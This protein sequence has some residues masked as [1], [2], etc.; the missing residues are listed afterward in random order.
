M[1]AVVTAP[2]LVR[3]AAVLGKDLLDVGI[4]AW[5]GR[6]AIQELGLK[7]AG[8]AEGKALP[9]LTRL[10]PKIQRQM[11]SRGWTRQEIIDAFERGKAFPAVDRTAGSTAATRYVN[12]TTGKFVVVNDATGN[13]IQVGGAGFVPH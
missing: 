3:D 13:V 11:L 2:F 1:I 6:G 9:A 7:A 12:P 5:A 10:S 4:E 8:T